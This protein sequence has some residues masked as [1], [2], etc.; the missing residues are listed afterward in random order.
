MFFFEKIF[1][2]EDWVGEVLFY[3][4]QIPIESSRWFLP[5]TIPSAALSHSNASLPLLF[6]KKMP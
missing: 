6:L 5:L 4:T 2:L 1:L 3:G